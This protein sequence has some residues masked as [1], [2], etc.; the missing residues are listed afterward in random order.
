MNGL[1][2]QRLESLAADRS[3]AYPA[4]VEG[5]LQHGMRRLWHRTLLTYA[6]GVGAVV[7]LASALFMLHPAGEDALRLSGITVQAGSTSLQPQSS[8][9]LTAE[10]KYS[11]G[12]T[13]SLTGAV[14]WASE[15]A[16]IAAVDGNGRVV[17]A[18]PGTTTITASKDD[19][20]GSILLTVLDQPP[21]KLSSIEV[22]PAAATLQAGQTQKLRV[23][24]IYSD[25]ST[26]DL[27]ISAGW[28]SSDSTVA[29]VDGE[30][31]V[32]GTAPGAAAVTVTQE[33][34]EA[35]AQITVSPV[36]VAVTVTGITINPATATLQT[37]QKQQFTA[38]F[39]LSDGSTRPAPAP[40]W[41]TSNNK[42]VQ[43]DGAGLATAVGPGST[44]ATATISAAQDGFT[45][46]ATV[47]VTPG[48]VI[49]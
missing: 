7:V 38:V 36:V 41:T 49:G 14:R 6:A 39:T 31:Q 17:A 23:R 22:T 40:S 35:T 37:G 32:T 1:Q 3:A 12:S 19:V 4:D 33:G 24:G 2:R 42:V 28:Q 18:A 30:G 27:T 11:D 45:G 44:T 21:A 46:T 10:G 8:E 26:R 34:L 43:I 13:Q 47:S 5:A 16:D 15:Q 48:N 25:G 9:Q 29:S 20:E